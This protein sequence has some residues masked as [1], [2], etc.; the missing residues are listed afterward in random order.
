MALLDPIRKLG[1]RMNG[2][3]PAANHDLIRQLAAAIDG[4]RDDYRRYQN[5]Y[6]GDH[7]TRLTDRAK[8]YLE[9]SG[10]RWSENFCET[11]IDV[12]AE[13]LSVTGFTS[14]LAEDTEDDTGAKTTADPLGEAFADWWQRNRMDAIQTDVHT[15]CLVKRDAYLIAEWDAQHARPR[16]VFNR[17]EM[18]HPVYADDG[19]TLLRLAKKWHATTVGPQNP[20]GR[21]IVRLNVYYPDRVE[22]YFSLSGDSEA[23]WATWQDEG[24]VGWPVPWIDGADVPLGIPVFHFRNKPLGHALGRSELR[25]VIPGQD[26]LNKLILDLN[27]FCD[28]VAVPQDWATGVTSDSNTFTR[29]HDIWSAQDKDAR[30]GRLEAGD[31][32]ALLQAIEQT[33]SRMARRSRTPLHLLTG[34]DMPSGESLKAAEAGLVAKVESA[35]VWLGNVWEDAML[36]GLRLAQTFGELPK[37]VSL[38]PSAEVLAFSQWKDP[39]SRNDKEQ[40]EVAALQ[41]DA[42]VSRYT[43]LAERG[44][45]P[46]EEAIRRST[47][48]VQAQEALETF[49]ANGEATAPTDRFQR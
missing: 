10:L 48:T 47:E 4:N 29:A 27:A 34:G 20:D 37:G 13:R 42:G 19:Q 11:I 46:A 41:H 28:N 1:L 18:I 45:D 33:L 44:Y 31:G 32:A 15:S 22:K 30:F 3:T 23:L 2:L 43:I 16:Y 38:D 9:A 6:D 12:Y 40:W 14:S 39:E 21:T 7:E 25:N 8:K 24:D 26:A 17:P 5:Y 35:Q 36:F 49:M